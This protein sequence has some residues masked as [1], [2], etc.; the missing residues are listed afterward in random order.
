MPVVGDHSGLALAAVRVLAMCRA[1][2]TLIFF[3]FVG[4][5]GNTRVAS[6]L[7]PTH[8]PASGQLSILSMTKLRTIFL[9]GDCTAEHT[10]EGEH[11]FRAR[12]NQGPALALPSII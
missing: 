9:L 8:T 2:C 1:C 6:L 10:L 5:P 3:F 11:S 12:G 4:A 7:M